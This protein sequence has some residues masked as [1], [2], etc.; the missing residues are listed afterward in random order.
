MSTAA[1]L[2][3]AKKRRGPQPPNNLNNKAYDNNRVSSEFKHE[4]LTV[5]QLLKRHEL[6]LFNLEKLF[7]NIKNSNNEDSDFISKKDLEIL[8]LEKNFSGNNSKY[9][10]LFENNK[11]EISTLKN[12]SE[13]LQK[14]VTEMNSIIQNLK[15]TII[16]QESEISSLKDK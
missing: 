8:L 7:I 6:R 2:T 12:N 5:V 1:S 14:T 16:R 10:N 3:A 15:A 11:E 13:S 4:N 9:D